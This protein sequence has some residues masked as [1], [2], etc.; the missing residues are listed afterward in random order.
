MIIV[1]DTSILSGLLLV[2]R[3][4]LLG[5]VYNEVIIPKVV[6]NELLVLKDFG[7]EL[8]AINE[9]TW[10]KIAEPSNKELEERLKLFL[11]KGESA[12][13]ALAQELQPIYLAIDERKGREV[14]ESMGIPIIGLIGI[15]I[16]AKKMNLISEVKP[17]LDELI[18]KA[19]FRVSKKL[20]TYILKEIGE[21][22]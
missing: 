15:L 2:N 11:D 5:D 7:Y 21:S 12:A 8:A 17:V 20:Y 14:A 13:I 16:I 3:I 19:G 10:L 4:D 18:E 1:S 9:V 22:K 6:F